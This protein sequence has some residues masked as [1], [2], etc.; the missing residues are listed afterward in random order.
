MSLQGTALITGT[1]GG[2][3]A[4]YAQRL[5]RPG[6]DLTRVGCNRGRLDRLSDRISDETGR[7]V[8]VLAALAGVESFLKEDAS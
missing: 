4:A 3:D 5:A 8:Q 7:A 1:S 2:I 6:Y